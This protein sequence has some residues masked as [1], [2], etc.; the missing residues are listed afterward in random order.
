MIAECLGELRKD[1]STI[2][3]EIGL[4]GCGSCGEQAEEV[5]MRRS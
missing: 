1:W 4:G 3:T 2:M 5:L